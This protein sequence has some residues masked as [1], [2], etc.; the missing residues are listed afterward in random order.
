MDGDEPG[1][2]SETDEG[3]DE[4]ELELSDLDPNAEK[5]A[6][7]VERQLRRLRREMRG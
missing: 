1:E 5:Q 7:K 2:G 3:T 6:R 4:E